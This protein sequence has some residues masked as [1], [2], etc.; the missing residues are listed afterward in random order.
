MILSQGAYM[1]G[2][3]FRGKLHGEGTMKLENGFLYRGQ[4]QHGT[5]L[6]GELRTPEYTYEGQFNDAGLPHGKGRSE[7]LIVS[8]RLIFEGLWEQGKMMSGTCVDENGNPIDYVNRADLQQ[9]FGTSEQCTLHEYVIAKKAD[10]QERAFENVSEYVKEA[11]GGTHPPSR[12]ALG[13]PHKD[14]PP[15]LPS[16]TPR[17]KESAQHQVRRDAL[18]KQAIPT[19]DAEIE[20]HYNSLDGSALSARGVDMRGLKKQL[21]F[22]YGARQVYRDTIQDQL[23]R[24]LYKQF[25]ST[26]SLSGPLPHH[27]PAS[28]E[29]KFENRNEPWVHGYHQT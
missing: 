14:L 9:V 23:N 1:E 17:Y 22:E 11:G 26:T 28:W 16:E 3:F 2:S 20:A 25:G 29:R 10:V 8:P 12:E 18:L 27:R 24:Y 21:R 7:Q 13:Y 5:I 6:Q 19:L 15:P 4:F